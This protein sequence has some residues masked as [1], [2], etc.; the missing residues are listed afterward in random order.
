MRRY[1][2]PDFGLDGWRIDVANMTGRYGATDR[3]RDVAEAVRNAVLEERPDAYLVGEHFHDFL[4]DLD[5][6]GWQ[7]VMNYSGFTKPIW[8]WL[9]TGRLPLDNWM[10]IPWDG[11]PRRAGLLGRGLDAEFLGR[12]MAAPHREHEH[13]LQPRFAPDPHDHR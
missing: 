7:G 12:R 10:G 9:N 6:A 3:N 11:W 4:D 5:G 13:H 8:S 2:R 1:L